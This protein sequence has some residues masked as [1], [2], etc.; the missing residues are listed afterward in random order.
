MQ[1]EVSSACLYVALE[2]FQR[3]LSSVC[4]ATAGQPVFD[5]RRVQ[6]FSLLQS[7][8]TG[9]EAH[10]ASYPMGNGG[11]FAGGKATGA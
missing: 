4:I 11:S 10:P 1:F 6:N 2:P 8:Q 7:V 9:S 3:R 5:S